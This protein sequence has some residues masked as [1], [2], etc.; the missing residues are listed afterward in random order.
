MTGKTLKELNVQVGDVVQYI[1]LG[2]ITTIRKIHG[3]KYYGTGDNPDIPYTDDPDFTLVSRAKKYTAWQ[4]TAA[5]ENAE[6]H[7]MPDGAIAW[8]VE[9]KPVK[10]HH[11]MRIEHNGYVG[12]TT[13][14]AID[15]RP[16]DVSIKWDALV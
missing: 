12:Y 6:T 4:F 9:V 7:T 16:Q 2:G 1:P 11:P 3:I 13:I 14:T 8:R 5:P 15:G 10:T